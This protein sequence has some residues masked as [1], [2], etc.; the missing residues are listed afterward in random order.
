MSIDLVS[1]GGQQI[2]TYNASVSTAGTYDFSLKT[3]NLPSGAYLAVLHSG[4]AVQT[5]KVIVIH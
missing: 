5:L 1:T 4:R 3:T 2:T